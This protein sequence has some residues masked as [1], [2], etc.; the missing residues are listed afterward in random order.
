[1]DLGTA[2]VIVMDKKTDLIKAI[3][4]YQGF[5]TMKA[6]VNAH[7]VEKGQGGY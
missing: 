7:H 3:T 6:V 5:T 1:M 4:D 2:G